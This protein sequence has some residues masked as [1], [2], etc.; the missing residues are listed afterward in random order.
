MDRTNK[1]KI[2]NVIYILIIIVALFSNLFT[3]RLSVLLYI[4]PDYSYSGR[5]EIHFIDVGQGDAIAIKFANGKIMVID[6]GTDSSS[7]KLE[8]Y[9][10]N[11]ILDERKMI[12]YLVL[13]HVD[14]D[15]SANMKY[16]LNT[17]NIGVFY[18]PKIYSSQEDASSTNTTFIY[19]EI[20]NIALEKGVEMAFNENGICIQEGMCKLTWLSPIAINHNDDIDSNDFS[21]VIKLVEGDK[22][23]LF[24]GDI[25][26]DTEE[27]LLKNY[28]N[29][30]LDC[31]IL[32]VSH[33]G[34]AYSTCDDF[35]NAVSPYY[36]IISVGN[37]TYGHPSND[38]LYRFLEYDKNTNSNLL[39]N[40]YT[41]LDN[42]NII[43][44]FANDINFLFIDNIDDY[45]FGNY[46]VYTVI[47]TI[48]ITIILVKPYFKQWKKYMR[49]VIQ[50]KQFEKLYNSQKRNDSEK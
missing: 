14:A 31:D 3:N 10:D 20:I 44:R 37:N 7:S 36:A 9:L 5:T 12:D 19:D 38:L 4:I 28:S 11:I 47:L 6:S 13:T 29:E 1:R 15:H 42:G 49:F 40:T 50:N 23:I 48:F 16:L 25:S 18:R 43:I 27:L 33:H 22:S 26:S 2:I 8:R 41:T 17:Y 45:S 24:T 35:L 39:G 32:K 46:F 30:D 34:S 21:P